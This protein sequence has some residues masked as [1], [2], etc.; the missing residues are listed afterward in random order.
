MILV[1]GATERADVTL[2]I[3]DGGIGTD[4]HIDEDERSFGV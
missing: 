4:C 2:V 3:I 1:G